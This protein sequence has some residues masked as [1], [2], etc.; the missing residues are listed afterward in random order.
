MKAMLFAA[1]LG[2][3]LRPLTDRLPKPLVR[4]AGR[5]MIDYPLFLL[6]HYGIRDVVVNVHHMGAML[7]DYLGDGNKLGLNITYS[8]E[9][10]LL[11]TGGGLLKARPFLDRGTFVVINSD[12]LIDL[13]LQRAIERHRASRAAATFVLRKDADADR[14]GAIEI[15]GDGRVQKFLKYEAPSIAA[16]G[17]LEKFM[18]TGVQILE[19]VIFDF[20]AEE[21]SRRFGTTTATYPKMLV[22]GERLEGFVFDGFWQDLGTPQRIFEAEA[23]L[24]SGEAKL[25][26]L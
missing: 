7:S 18:F 23:K 5:P 14:Y 12:V 4:V 17:P 8:E 9:T 16:A 6:R 11:D 25:G 22:R 15:S 10:E 21:Q 20:M 26:Y 13:D 1:G 2:T 19:P 3:R 24:A